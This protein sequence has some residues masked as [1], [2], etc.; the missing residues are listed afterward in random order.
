ME[1]RPKLTIKQYDDNEEEYGKYSWAVFRSDSPKPIIF[2]ISNDHA[3]HV[4]KILL[5]RAN[6]PYSIPPIKDWYKFEELVQP[7]ENGFGIENTTI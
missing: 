7:D 2:G 6:L 4:L 5:R 1:Q 3:K